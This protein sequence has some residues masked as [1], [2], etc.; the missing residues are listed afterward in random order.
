MFEVTQPIGNH[1][2]SEGQ[3]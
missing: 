3:I 2:S 1:F